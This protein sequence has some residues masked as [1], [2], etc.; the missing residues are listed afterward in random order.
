MARASTRM[1]TE[2]TPLP[3]GRT[4]TSYDVAR[5]AGVSQSAVSRCFTPGASVS[6][7]TRERVMRAVD[8]LGYQPNA[9]ARTLITKR[10]NLVA[11]IV[12]NLAFAP[13]LT[14]ALS[15]QLAARGL[16]PL[17]FTLDHE[18]DVDRVIDQLWQ[19]RV[20][21]VVS[22]AQLSEHHILMLAKRHLPLVFLNRAYDSIAV[23]SVC[24]DQA[25]GERWLVDRLCAAGHSRFAIIAGPE[26]SMVSRQRVAGAADRLVAS[27]KPRPR[28]AVGDFT[29]DGGRAA[30]R[31][32]AQDEDG[33]PEAVICA[34]DMMA[35]GCIDEA[36]FALGLRVPED[37]SV[38]GFDGSAPG[39]WAS[40]DLV[41]VRQP[42]RIMVDA[43][44]D[45]LAARIED[46]LLH[47]EKR[48]FSGELVAGRSARLE[49]V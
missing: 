36:R 12:A 49:T 45:M 16:N 46:P 15:R 42:T 38:V 2:A 9:I 33:V 25:E 34:N 41:T 10:S 48:M 44:I 13:E 43:A 5:H 24:C 3:P 8:A 26:E 39:G 27:G 47:N 31:T 7:A 18:I 28:V 32:L 11:V 19:Y 6:R 21:G 35:I 20:D 22:A 23:N 30:M 37:V 17:L 14:A 40:Y 1:S 4:M 29:Y